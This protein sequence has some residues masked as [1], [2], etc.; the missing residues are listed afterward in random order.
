MPRIT[1]RHIGTGLGVI[2]FA[3]LPYL[4]GFADVLEVLVGGF[5]AGGVVLL[6]FS[7]VPVK[8]WIWSLRIAAFVGGLAVFYPM[9][10][11][12]PAVASVVLGCAFIFTGAGSFIREELRYK[13]YCVFFWC[14]WFLSGLCILSF[15]QGDMEAG[16]TTA[17]YLALINVSYLFIRNKPS[18]IG[19]V[20]QKMHLDSQAILSAL[21]KTPPRVERAAHRLAVSWFDKILRWARL[22]RVAPTIAAE[23]VVKACQRFPD[24]QAGWQ[25]AYY[26]KWLSKD[27][28][29]ALDLLTEAKVHGFDD[30]Y[31]QRALACTLFQ[32]K[33]PRWRVVLEHAWHKSLD[34]GK[35]CAYEYFFAMQD[36]PTRVWLIDGPLEFVNLRKQL[37]RAVGTTAPIQAAAVSTRS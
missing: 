16:F 14:A 31:F 1:R 12:R 6:L 29:G 21:D 28:R 35:T 5:L 3:S 23:R 11:Q 24:L 22:Q 15:Y 17:C 30:A 18:L 32:L 2:L 25:L 34:E 13:I 36:D 4:G 19:D 20:F 7:K 10:N 33:D 9:L 27:Y 26:A 8:V 37:D